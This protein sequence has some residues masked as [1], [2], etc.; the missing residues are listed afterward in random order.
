MFSKK[1]TQDELTS[2]Y[3]Q[4]N[5]LAQENNDLKR[6]HAN[7]LSEL[8]QLKSHEGNATQVIDWDA[9]KA[10]S[11]ERIAESGST[12]IGWP[13]QYPVE[14]AGTIQMVT[15]IKEWKLYCSLEQHQRLAAEYRAW[16]S[17][18]SA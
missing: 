10:I 13:H 17:K 18:K 14:I 12:I 5:V 1:S 9:F 15:K 4:V 3:D 2:L 11:L 8:E 6:S 7:L 16:L